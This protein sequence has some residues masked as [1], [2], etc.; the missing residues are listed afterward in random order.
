MASLPADG[1]I[2]GDASPSSSLAIG[3]DTQDVL[4]HASAQLENASWPLRQ[5]EPNLP[6]RVQ[7]AP[8]PDNTE[9][10]NAKS[11]TSFEDMLCKDFQVNHV[12]DG[13]RISKDYL[14][15]LAG[16][17]RSSG[18]RAMM[19]PHYESVFLETANDAM[20]AYRGNRGRHLV[21][22][23]QYDND[24]TLPDLS[25]LASTLF[26]SDQDSGFGDFSR[27]GAS[28]MLILFNDPD[29]SL[30]H[31]STQKTVHTWPRF[32][33]H[34]W[35]TDSWSQEYAGEGGV[36]PWRENPTTAGTVPLRPRAAAGGGYSS[37]P[38][39][40]WVSYKPEHYDERADHAQP[41]EP[42]SAP[43]THKAAAGGGY[44]PLTTRE[45]ETLAKAMTCL[46]AAPCLVA[47]Q[48]GHG[49]PSPRLSHHA[50][51]RNPGVGNGLPQDRRVYRK[52]VHHVQ[53]RHHR[54][55]LALHGL[56]QNVDFEIG[57]DKNVATIAL[58]L[59]WGY[60]IWGGP[61]PKRTREALLRT[62][63]Q[64]QSTGSNF[65]SFPNHGCPSTTRADLKNHRGARIVSLNL[66]KSMR[67]VV[68]NL[69][70]KFSDHFWASTAEP[71]AS[72][73]SSIKL[74]KF[75]LE[76]SPPGQT[77]D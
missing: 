24:H 12:D 35:L 72:G 27:Y 66:K 65:L 56:Q 19:R 39:G 63:R 76:T 18:P 4:N 75:R 52:F 64:H 26:C 36:S 48:S 34:N 17:P 58:G 22:A 3:H 77:D 45:Q 51:A 57:P 44:G 1:T 32:L 70:L 41:C 10:T 11:H 60:D 42:G 47:F 31:I 29:V 33:L 54:W 53:Q 8:T 73:S 59:G 38:E 25:T 68:N 61:P 20:P 15:I 6:A 67:Q 69:W 16:S 50:R 21:D 5:N 46:K 71:K 37:R 74:S 13:I 2:R 7:F 55:A 40:R 28:Q 9:A 49:A 43:A 23:V 62:T 30:G 14:A